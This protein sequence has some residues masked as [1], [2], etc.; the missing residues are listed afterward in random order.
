[1]EKLKADLEMLVG[2]LRNSIEFKDRLE[3]LMSVYPFNEYEYVISTLLD[4]GILTTG[5]YYEL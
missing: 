1:M 3:N 4:E 2:E 5:D